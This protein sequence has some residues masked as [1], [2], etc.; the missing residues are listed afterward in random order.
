M[1]SV[2][3]FAKVQ[4]D[5]VFKREGADIYVDIPIPFTQAI[6]GGS[7]QV[8]TLTGDVVLKVRFISSLLIYK[9]PPLFFFLFFFPKTFAAMHMS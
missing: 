9:F 2:R 8:P 5:K 4:P 1:I 3:H 7:V 6:L